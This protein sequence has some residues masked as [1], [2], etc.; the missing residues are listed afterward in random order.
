MSVLEADRS[1]LRSERNLQVAGSIPARPI[2]KG[3]AMFPGPGF[4]SARA[5][6]PLL[7]SSRSWRR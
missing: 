1:G 2:E 6:R 7:W 4:R 5:W 3:L